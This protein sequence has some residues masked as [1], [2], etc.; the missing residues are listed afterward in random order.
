MVEDPWR[1]EGGQ[2]PG[3]KGTYISGYKPRCK[4]APNCR[5]D[6]NMNPKHYED[7]FHPDPSYYLNHPEARRIAIAKRQLYNPR[8]YTGAPAV[9]YGYAQQTPYGAPDPYGAPQPYPV[10]PRGFRGG[11][12]GPPMRAAPAPVAYDQYQ[13]Y[14]QTGAPMDPY[15]AYAQPQPYAAYGYQQPAAAYQQQQYQDPSYQSGAYQ[16]G[17]YQTQPSATQPPPTAQPTGG[18]PAAAYRQHSQPPATIPTRGASTAATSAT[19]PSSSGGAYLPQG[20]QAPG[21]DPTGTNTGYDQYSQYYA[22]Y[23]QGYSAAPAPKR[24]RR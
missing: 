3:L 24:F 10:A 14:D 15:A 7:F 11:Y 8:G 19:Q 5:E 20:T 22:G 9:P 18:N 1:G 21:Y 4:Y 6:R 12:R 2:V 23:G 16:S 13:G 17:A